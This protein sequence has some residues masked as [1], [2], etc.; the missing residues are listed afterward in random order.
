[1][2]DERL[3]K[4]NSQSWKIEKIGKLESWKVGKLES[5]KVVELLN[6]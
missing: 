1:M 5:W 6:L 2:N 4:Q 3:P